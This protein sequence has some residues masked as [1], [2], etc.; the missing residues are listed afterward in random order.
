MWWCPPQNENIMHTETDTWI[1][2]EAVKIKMKY[3]NIINTMP[4]TYIS[5]DS[6]F[7]KPYET[8]N[9]WPFLMYKK[10]PSFISVNLIIFKTAIINSTCYLS[11]V[12]LCVAVILW[13]FSFQS[14]TRW[15]TFRNIIAG[16]FFLG[17]Y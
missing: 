15:F 14:E 5:N 10:T 9:I 12:V 11:S 1:F 7:V 6:S 16:I 4:G 3:V 13:T 2:H 8:A 17:V